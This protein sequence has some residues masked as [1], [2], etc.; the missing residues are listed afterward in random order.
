MTAV[1]IFA[2]LVLLLTPAAAAAED[3]ELFAVVIGHNGGRPGL[4]ALRYA[5]DDA[6]RIALLLR[7]LQ[8]GAARIWLLT[9]L[10]RDTE[11]ALARAGIA[12]PAHRSPTRRALDQAFAE[13]ATA[14][15]APAR[16][17]R[18]LYVLYAGHGLRGR[19]LLAPEAGGEAA[20]TGGELRARLAAVSAL[21][22]ALRMLL[23]VDAC[24]SQSLFADRDAEPG[25]DFSAEVTALERRARRLPLGVLTAA[26]A[27]KPAG[28]VAEL[29]AGFFSHALASGLAG[30]ADADGDEVVS[31]GELAAFVAFNTQRLTG[32]LP[33]F[34]PPGG[35]LGAVAID[36]RGRRPRLLLP[37]GAGGR[38]LV[39]AEPGLPVFVEAFQDP[40]RP[41]RLSL[42][43]G[44]YRIQRS[45]PGG[46]ISA[47]T[48]ELRTG[49]LS[50][51]AALAWGAAAT[52]SRDGEEAEM[53]FSAPFSPEVVSTLEAGFRAG[54]EPPTPLAG[55]R[56]RLAVT[57]LAG[58]A[59]LLGG[60]EL[61]VGLH[62]RR[63]L[64]PV[65]L[66]GVRAAFATSSHRGEES[67]RLQ[68]HALTVEGGAHWGVAPWLDLHALLG[69]GVGGLVRR[70]ATTSGDLLGP[71]LSAGVGGEAAL[72][73]GFAL[74]IEGRAFLQ[75]VR[76]DDGRERTGGLVAE[77]GVG[78]AF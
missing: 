3:G 40:A 35:D 27:G 61:G 13:L 72:G 14:L 75:W 30:A 45:E 15:R 4:P 68:H 25:P 70:A 58:A 42:P 55:R 10:D 6:V 28:E 34:E 31:F 39:E 54:R 29:R 11:A 37:A 64:G 43:A 33:W 77:M 47:A 23:F 8:P 62:A 20:M 78:Y 66:A 56:T 5:D 46:A 52:G 32:Q 19:V 50:D 12:A 44:R 67:Y 65:A 71:L 41:L 36:H 51:G 22:P 7:G 69:A 74:V 49:E 17:P 48:V 16:G 63:A 57:S 73:G 26:A 1:R 60:V 9:D 76:I 59:P 18:V 38:F 53:A 21:D 2:A 24:R